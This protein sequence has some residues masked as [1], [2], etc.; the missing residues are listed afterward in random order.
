MRDNS[1]N[2]KRAFTLFF[3]S[4]YLC[5]TEEQSIMKLILHILAVI[6]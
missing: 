6:I 4:S 5:Y 1:I 3:Q 2:A